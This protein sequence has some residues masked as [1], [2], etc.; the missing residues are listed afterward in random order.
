MAYL[1]QLRPSKK[2]MG[3]SHSRNKLA[4]I[5]YKTL[6]GCKAQDKDFGSKA[7]LPLYMATTQ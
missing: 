3:L 6:P 1:F 5:K 4:A 7:F 2:D